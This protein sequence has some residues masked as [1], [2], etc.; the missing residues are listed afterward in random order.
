MKGFKNIF[1]GVAWSI[2]SNVIGAG[3]SFLSVP[4]LLTY[5]GKEQYG[6]IGI[7]LSVNVYLRI[8]DMGFSSG[9]VK[10]F[11]TYLVKNDLDG[12]NKLF[13]SSLLFYISI[14][15]IN[16]LILFGL[17]FYCQEIFHLTI[18]ENQ[19]FK[20]LL[21]ILIITS[22]PV[23][24]SNVME[25]LLRAK[26]L[27]A[28]QQRV[29]LLSK[30]GQI[31]SMLLTI[32]LKL[33]VVS[34]FAINTCSF[35]IVIPFYIARIK[36]MSLGLSFMPMYHKKAMAEV[37][38]YCLSVF[39][40]GLFQFSANYLRPVLLGMKLGLSVVTDFRLIEGIANLIL[41][42]GSSF[43]GVILPHATKAKALGD[44]E[45]E[46]QIASNGTKYISIFLAFLIFSFVLSSKEI[47]IMYVGA[48]NSYLS[49]WFNIWAISLLGLHSSALSSIV[50]SGNVLR[51]IVYMSAFSTIFS[52]TA[53]WFLM[54]YFGMGGV[55]I[56]Y[57]LY[58]ILQMGYY[59]IYYYPTKLGYNSNKIFIH[60]FFVPVVS[61]GCICL[62]I[63]NLSAFIV[64]S[65]LYYAVLYKEL[66][67]VCLAIP[68]AYSFFFDRSEKIY[69]AD[70]V[71]KI[72][73]KI[74]TI[75]RP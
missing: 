41:I 5:F 12:L 37:L 66:L 61:I 30:I 20:K 8:L 65:K 26:E 10:F 54:N 49:Y 3:Y 73:K 50:L 35:L 55:I 29:L 64:F 31:A 72:T 39:S 22:F 44:K 16:A 33:S 38:P 9:N 70:K 56:S 71:K 25:Q 24:G 34:F 51:P 19:V 23:W 59:Y 48:E 46:M 47:I 14:A 36:N 4:L 18:E 15:L 43:L 28:W 1:G 63:Y 17:S 74:K 27:V 13:Q 2:I 32:F 40:F 58:V 60:S 21:Y 62:A 42:L 6:L 45:A 69:I 7:A 67:F 52:L 11:S 57:S 68:V 75:N 53:A